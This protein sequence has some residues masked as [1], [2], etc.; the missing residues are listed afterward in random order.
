MTGDA[1]AATRAAA[2]DP[3]RAARARHLSDR[4]SPIV[5]KELR[6]GVRS[7]LFTGAFLLQQFLLLLVVS[8]GFLF[9]TR[10]SRAATS[11]RSSSGSVLALPCSWCCPWRGALHLGRDRGPHAGAGAAD[12][13]HALARGRGQVGGR[14]GP[15]AGAHHR[16]AA[17]RDGALLPGSG[18]DRARPHVPGRAPGLLAAA[19]RAG[20]GRVGGAT[21][22]ALP[23][24]PGRGGGRPTAVS[25]L[26]MVG[27]TIFSGGCRLP[28]RPS[29]PRPPSPC[30]RCWRRWKRGRS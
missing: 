19:G 22:G 17:V 29:C 21:V 18:G 24:A 2:L 3:A 7:H 23:L 8:L 25:F 11:S 1:G 20:R 27:D 28:R 5:V 26:V 10:P 14:R 13:A 15:V 16:G 9:P 12:A 30:S 6:Q 4:L